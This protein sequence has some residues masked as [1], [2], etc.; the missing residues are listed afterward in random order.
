M[1]YHCEDGVLKAMCGIVQLITYNTYNLTAYNIVSLS[2]LIASS[3]NHNTF[4]FQ[5][6]G[7]SWCAVALAVK[8]HNPS[9]CI[10]CLL[11]TSLA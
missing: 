2:I 10:L 4:A 3:T 8:Q 6:F 11:H 5:Q 1:Y 7:D 9:L